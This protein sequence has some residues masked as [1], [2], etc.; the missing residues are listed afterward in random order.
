MNYMNTSYQHSFFTTT[1]LKRMLIGGAI[2]LTMMMIFLSGVD[3][4]DPSW[5][6]Y[7]MVRP[8]VVIAFAGAAGGAFFH[9]MSPFRLKG[10]WK[11]FTALFLSLLVFIFCLWI[12][13]VLGLDGTLWD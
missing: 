13:S 7:W 8:L 3:E 2:G 11:K 6:Q 9:L 1:L 4:P 10:G 5:P 12:G